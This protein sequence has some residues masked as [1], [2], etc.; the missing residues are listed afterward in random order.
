MAAQALQRNFIVDMR[1]PS[2]AEFVCR[3]F[4]MILEADDTLNIDKPIN[5]APSS[6]ETTRTA[7]KGSKTSLLAPADKHS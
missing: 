3:L 6:S 1:N 7:I 4:H 2:D 5:K